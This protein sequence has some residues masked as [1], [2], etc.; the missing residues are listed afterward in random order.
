[1]ISSLIFFIQFIFN[2]FIFFDQKF[3]KNQN[4]GGG[5]QCSFVLSGDT[6]ILLDNYLDDAIVFFVWK[7]V[8]KWSQFTIMHKYVKTNN[9]FGFNYFSRSK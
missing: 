6:S 2:F 4:G 5:A 9:P 7:C 8:Y 1:M 3:H